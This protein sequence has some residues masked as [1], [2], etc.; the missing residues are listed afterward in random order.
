[1]SRNESEHA[2]AGSGTPPAAG[3]FGWPGMGTAT[4]SFGALQQGGPLGEYLTDAVQRTVLF[5]DVLRQRSDQYCAQ[6]PGAPW[7]CE[8]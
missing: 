8:T 2:V 4:G 6:R 5:R 7:T 3:W 1:M